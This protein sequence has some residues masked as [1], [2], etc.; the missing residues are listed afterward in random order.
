LALSDVL[1]IAIL[2]I[3]VKGL[4]RLAKILGCVVA[5]GNWGEVDR[6]VIKMEIQ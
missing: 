3:E 6:D 1:I 5:G 2:T 4:L